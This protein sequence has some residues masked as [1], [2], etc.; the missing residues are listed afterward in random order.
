MRSA[1][2][3]S[4]ILAFVA[5]CVGP[6][7]DPPAVQPTLAALETLGLDCGNATKDNVPSGLFQ[8]S[9]AGAI[10]S[11]QS[12]VLVDGNA[13]GVAGIT[14]VVDVPGDP[15]GARSRFGRLVDVV[16]PL[17]A[18]PVLK[19]SVAGWTGQ[20]QTWTVGGVRIYADCLTA[21]CMFIVMPAV[22]ALRPLPLP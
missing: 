19:D 2:G 6:G 1:I 10:E 9:C 22:D 14:L 13:D 20:Q 21:H 8:W 16:P 15:A 5:G 17:S 3:A 4:L 11:R 18:A 7:N 12:S